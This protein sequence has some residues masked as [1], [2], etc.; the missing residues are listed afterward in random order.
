M[1]PTV[2]LSI[3]ESFHLKRGKD[4]IIYAGMPSDSVY[5]IVQM[6]ESGY[7]GYAWPMF[8]PRNKQEI[9]VD[10][11]NLSVENATPEEIRFKVR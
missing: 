6:K 7:Q 2:A 3:G 4:R 1:N 11:V 8:Y 5:C 10:G 9:V